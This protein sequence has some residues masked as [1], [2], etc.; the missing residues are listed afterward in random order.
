MKKILLFTAAMSFATICL[1][2]QLLA[3]LNHNDSIT[4]YYGSTALSQAYNAAESGDIITLSSGSFAAVDIRKAITIRGAGMY[5]DT[6]L[7][8]APTLI[9]GDFTIDHFAGTI[10]SHICL[11]GL[12]FTHSLY[13]SNVKHPEFIKC[14]FTRIL[15]TFPQGTNYYMENATFLNCVV[16]DYLRMGIQYANY[17]YY[18]AAIQNSSFINCA[19]MSVSYYSNRNTSYV[20]N[21][22]FSASGKNNTF[23]NCIVKLHPAEAQYYSTNNSILFYNGEDSSYTSVTY[24]SIG[25]NST[26][27]Y[28]SPA[29][30]NAQNLHNYNSFSSVFKTFTGTYNSG[31]TSFELQDSIATSILGTDGTQV[32]I[33]GGAMPFDPHIHHPLVRRCNVASR[34]TADGKLAVDIEIVSE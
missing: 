9:T 15:G 1:G 23:N 17:G 12:Y 19:I 3:T 21:N 32:G 2:Q 24:N 14:E 28:F 29:I 27:P 25:I 10:S 20:S 13:F 16:S 11:E 5:V 22:Y 7:G 4:V 31:G 18:Y 34:S 33:Y 6:L 30:L 8:T 26:A